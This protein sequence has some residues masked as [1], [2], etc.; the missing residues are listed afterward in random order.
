MADRV[1]YCKD[2]IKYRG[3]K[4]K[5]CFFSDEMGIRLSEISKPKK[6]WMQAGME[7]ENERVDDDIKLNCWGAISWKGATSL[8]IFSENLNNSLYQEIVEKHR[9]E[10]ENLYQQDF[11][12]QHDKHPFH[13]TFEVFDEDEDVEIIDFPTYSP[14]LIRLRT[15]G[16]L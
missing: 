13:L 4:I 12:Y 7:L 14:I 8:H 5:R 1:D 9:E 10:M 6:H 11:C 15:Y 16:P 3:R 2:M